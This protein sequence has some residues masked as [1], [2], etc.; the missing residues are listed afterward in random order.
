MDD[1]VEIDY[2]LAEKVLSADVV[3]KM[4]YFQVELF[5]IATWERDY[6]PCISSLFLI[7]SGGSFSDTDK[8]YGDFFVHNGSLVGTAEDSEIY[9]KAWL[10][11]NN[12]KDKQGRTPL[13]DDGYI[14]TFKV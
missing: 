10:E 9:Y 12:L 13:K 3:A 4:K 7:C 14:V 11:K 2:E 5:H 6:E 8:V 1:R